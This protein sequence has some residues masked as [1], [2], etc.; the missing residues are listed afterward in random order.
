MT[1]GRGRVFEVGWGRFPLGGG[2]D[3]EV[4]AG[5]D[6]EEGGVRGLGAGRVEIPAASAGM[7]EWGARV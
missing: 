2:N 1:A 7:T 5:G 3:E 6:R 4:G